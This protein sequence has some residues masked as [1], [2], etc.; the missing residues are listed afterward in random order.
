M[1]INHNTLNNFA[2]TLGKLIA[3]SAV[4][5]D[6][7]S[8]RIVGQRPSDHVLAGF[9]TPLQ[10]GKEKIEAEKKG[11][12]SEAQLDER[13]NEDLPQDSPYEQTGV[14][15]E[16][17][18]PRDALSGPTQMKVT[19]ECAVYVRRMPT[20]AEQHKY[21][22]QKTK[23]QKSS[24]TAKSNTPIQG[25]IAAEHYQ[26]P[27]PVWTRERPTHPITLNI[28]LSQLLRNHIFQK[29]IAQD[30]KQ[31]LSIQG[32]R[33]PKQSS[34]IPIEMLKEENSYQKWLEGVSPI[35][36]DRFWLPVVDIRLSAVPTE[37]HYVRLALRIINRTPPNTTRQQE[38]FFDPNIY[39]VTI[40]A[41]ISE[42]A[43]HPSTFR[44]LPQ[45]Y[46]YDC[47]MPGIGINAHMEYQKK[48]GR[49]FLTSNTVPQKEVARL[50]PRPIPQVI[51]KFA[52]LA[53]DPL[54]TLQA[55]LAAMHIYDKNAWKDKLDSLSGSSLNEAEED[56]RLFVQEIDG[57]ARGIRLLE[58]D[59]YPTI[60]RA[61]RLMNEAMANLGNL[62]DT[63]R[64]FQI[65]FIVSLLP[66]L[67]SREYPELA[68]AGDD[69]VDLL[70]FAAGGGKTEAFLGIILWQA[71]FDRLRRKKI[72]VTA[73]VR[74]PLRLLTFQQLQRLG[75]AL[76]KAELIRMR[77][78]LGGQRFSLG[79]FVGGQ[80][81]DNAINDDMHQRYQKQGLEESQRR[82][83]QCPF[84]AAPT[85]LKYNESLRLIEHHCTQSDCPGGGREERLPIYVVDDDLYRYLP[86]IIVSTVDKMANLGQ[87][88][89]F[90]N[91][92]GRFD[93]ICPR[94]GVSFVNS[95]GRR[96][97][98]AEERKNGGR[99]LY[100]EQEKYKIQYGPFHDPGPAL[101]VQDELHLLS[102]ELG[103]F[104]AH[105][106]TA[107]A[108]MSRSFGYLPWKVIAATAT[109]QN[110]KEHAWQLYLKTAQQF[111]CPGPAA[112]D[113]FYYR[114]NEESV[115]RIFLGL[116]GVGRKHTP[117]VTRALTITYLELDAA[118][119]LSERDPNAAAQK[120]GTEHLSP[121]EW[122]LLIFLYELPLIYTLTRK[123]SD[124]VAEAI[125][126]HVKK[127]L[128][129]LMSE[130]KELIIDMF[131]SGIDVPEM[132]E[133]MQTIKDA[134]SAS[135]PSQR[136]RGLVTTNII[137]HGVDIDRF[138]I[139]IFAGF[140]RLVSEYIQ[141]SA[142]VGRRYPGISLFIATPQSERDRG[143]FNRFAKFHEYLDRL[144]D[145]SALA[146]WP[147]PAVERTI[148]GVLSAYLMGVAAAEVE[149]G[150]A[151]VE[152]IQSYFGNLN[153]ESLTIEKLLEWM[154]KA[155]GT[156][157]APS[158]SRYKN[159]L[160]T[161][162]QNRYSTVI[163]NPKHIG[164]RPTPINT[165]LEAMRSLRDIDDPGFI[166]INDQA[167]IRVIRRLIRG[168][169]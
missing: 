147:L 168:E 153:A 166:R 159:K 87:N 116:V 63:W 20:L 66:I 126:S 134:D 169:E 125:E 106:E 6:D 22:T 154:N 124:M 45:S 56:H 38:D 123:G 37:P 92:L 142:R 104:D 7:A 43:H 79:F 130:Y 16:W 58:S 164:G 17:L 117:A 65:I 19:I 70:W 76:G 13:L 40:Q 129:D 127:D 44:E 132:I 141:A 103:T 93:M 155:Y 4:G 85:E 108:E 156:D 100:C 162:V 151:T 15:F 8:E 12:E 115:G 28:D 160:E 53:H 42:K 111:P 59:Q 81:T 102:E 83:F 137:G 74:F 2:R 145:P 97:S 10:N 136:I 90:S 73:F 30:L 78:K 161:T 49:V 21:G 61:F 131:N 35:T 34:T 112:Y 91:I 135:D 57:F 152:K 67:A 41:E 54:P 105:Y 98:A 120:Y 82:V 133:T 29:D 46:R 9:L 52:T 109:I 118:R 25:Q 47:N 64:L 119:Q 33:F 86:T 146:R 84:C 72:G 101:L 167:D 96:C 77:E 39:A 110:Y 88:Q 163:N 26:D 11:V 114:L 128:N 80:V 75:N 32:L 113:S 24:A 60:S 143:V 148:P 23:P 18:A 27:I 55:I 99:S 3:Q 157:Y 140:P 149:A 69:R 51:P 144:V 150:L 139:M 62:Y 68:Q 94:H 95:N 121:A 138:N 50:E 158:P 5:L 48:D 122:K 31:A 1:A 14:G 89:R 71:F 107:A 165:Y 36:T